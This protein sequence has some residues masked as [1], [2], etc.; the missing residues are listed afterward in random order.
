M[1]TAAYPVHQCIGFRR[2]LP[3]PQDLRAGSEQHRSLGVAA[4]VLVADE[5]R[6]HA[7]ASP[8]GTSSAVALLVGGWRSLGECLRI[9]PVQPIPQAFVIL[10]FAHDNV[11]TIPQ[12]PPP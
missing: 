2:L 4:A 8:A 9:G 10:P 3:Q 6:S 11:D 1:K 5:W 7:P 12:R